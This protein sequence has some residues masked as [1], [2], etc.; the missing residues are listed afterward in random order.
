[1]HH[2]S[3]KLKENLEPEPEAPQIDPR[4]KTGLEAARWTA[5]KA[6]Q[7]SGYIGMLHL[8]QDFWSNLGGF[9]QH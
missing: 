7:G 4:L 2:G 5:C 1:M 3:E 6:A 8:G 9:K